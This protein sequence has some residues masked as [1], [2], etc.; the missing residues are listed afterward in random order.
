MKPPVLRVGHA[1]FLDIDGTLIDL[2]PTPDMVVVPDG[3]RESLHALRET[4]GGALAILSGRKLTDIDRLVGPDFACAAEHGAIMRDPA[5][6]VTVIAQRLAAYDSWLKT[7]KQYENA[8]PGVLVEEKEFSLVLHYRRAPQHEAELGKLAEQ[9][10]GSSTDA[11]LMLAHCAFELKPR[12]GDKGDALA[13]FMARPP[14]ARRLPVF[15][16]DDVTD[17]PAIRMAASLGGAGLH[18]ARDFAGS[19]QAVRDWL[20]A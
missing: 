4:L 15:V 11:V 7:L 17:E 12:G 16:G 10:V 2:A 8:M 19:T 6:R 3:L 1:L 14:F 9:L 20:A 13:R 5:G 18:V